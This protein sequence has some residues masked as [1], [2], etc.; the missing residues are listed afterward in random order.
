MSFREFPHR[1]LKSP[2]LEVCQVEG[3][4][5]PRPLHHPSSPNPEAEENWGRSAANKTSCHKLKGGFPNRVVKEKENRKHRRFPG[6]PLPGVWVQ[7]ELGL[8]SRQPWAGCAVALFSG[9]LVFQTRKTSFWRSLGLAE[10][11]S[12]VCRLGKWPRA[13]KSS[14]ARALMRYDQG[15]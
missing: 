5:L 10:C 12:Q 3:P 14:L 13:N 9:R 11:I 8:G 15:Y 6:N 4:H 1:S 7:S 2:L